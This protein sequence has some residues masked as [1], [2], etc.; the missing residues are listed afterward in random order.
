[1]KSQHGQAKLNNSL[2]NLNKAAIR[3]KNK[4]RG[5]ATQKINIKVEEQN[6]SQELEELDVALEKKTNELEIQLS[7][8][9]GWDPINQFNPS[10]MLY[11]SQSRK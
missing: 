1:M 3:F 7:R 11:L 8:R 10:N 2:T 5:R 6:E 4:R 9:E